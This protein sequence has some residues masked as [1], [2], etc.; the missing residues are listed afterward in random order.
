[1]AGFK[2]RPTKK[3]KKKAVRR[4]GGGNE[5]QQ[6]VAALMSAAEED[7]ARG[8]HEAAL[9]ALRQ[10]AA[11]APDD[12]TVADTLGALLAETGDAQ[13]AVQ[14][15]QVAVSLQPDEGFEKYMYLGQL[16]NGQ[17]AEECVRKGIDIV[18]RERTAAELANDEAFPILSQQLAG[19]LCSLAELHLSRVS[20]D[21]SAEQAEL[22]SCFSECEALLQRA[23]VV[24]A[25]SPEPLQALVCVRI[26]QDR[27]DEAHALLMQSMHLW[28]LDDPDPSREPPSY[29]F[30]YEAAK[31]LVDFQEF[32]KAVEVL[33]RLLEEFDN[34]SDVWYLL[35]L[36]HSALSQWEQ[37]FECIE[38]GQQLLLKA[39]AASNSE[40]Q[41]L[42]LEL[43]MH[44][45]AAAAGDKKLPSV[46]EDTG[47]DVVME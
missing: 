33:E 24:D 34:A 16:L 36:A 31:L 35:A 28:R 5:A 47:T 43:K 11:L 40:T 3:S 39:G 29:E 15:L 45:E 44:V 25:E 42:F 26:E 8:E 13:E 14:V 30:R 18:H 41:T 21:E 20:S 7:A 2:P 9:A 32:E 1:M 17:G 4:V 22:D 10:A 38:T 6:Q 37:A 19:G 27:A 12:A 23:R 46:A